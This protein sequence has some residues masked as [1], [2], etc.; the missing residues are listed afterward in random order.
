[1]LSSAL[2]LLPLYVCDCWFFI[3]LIE[4]AQVFKSLSKVNYYCSLPH[5]IL[6]SSCI[7]LSVKHNNFGSSEFVMFTVS[8]S[9]SELLSALLRY[10]F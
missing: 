5:V 7:S 1:M 10:V 2:W 9:V 6:S 8:L 3:G 4:A